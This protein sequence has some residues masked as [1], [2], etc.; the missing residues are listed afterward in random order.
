M[1]KHTILVVED[2]SDLREAMKALLETHYNVVMA[3]NGYA[4]LKSSVRQTPNL[5]LMDLKMPTMDGFEACRLFRA[6]PELNQ[7]PILIVSG[8]ATDGDKRRALEMGANEFIPKPFDF[9]YLMGRIR[10]YLPDD[11]KMVSSQKTLT[12]GTLLKLGAIEMDLAAGKV[13][14]QK[15]DVHFSQLE[16]RLL[17][18]LVA[19]YERLVSREVIIE[20]VWAGENVSSKIMAPHFVSVRNKIQGCGYEIASVYGKG[21]LIRPSGV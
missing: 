4:G 15:K 16:F 1:L 13:S 3:E 10:A 20:K 12:Q 6:D 7:V 9:D 11:E 18:L 5:I 8:F 17:Q 21:Y 2:E 14:I 19:N